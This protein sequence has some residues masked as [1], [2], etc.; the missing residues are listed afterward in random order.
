[1]AGQREGDE[2]RRRRSGQELAWDAGVSGRL[3][4]SGSGRWRL[5]G[6]GRIPRGTGWR[7]LDGTNSLDFRVWSYYI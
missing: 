3:R 2:V 5:V 6:W 7:R 4:W 1:M